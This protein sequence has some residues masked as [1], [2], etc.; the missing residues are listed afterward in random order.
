[1]NLRTPYRLLRPSAHA[2]R[3]LPVATGAAVG[4]ALVVVPEALTTKLTDAH[5]T[6]LLRL[7]AVCAALGA[8]FV[9]DDAAARSIPTVP[10]SR[11]TRN[12]VRVAVA[13]PAVAL[14]WVG[15]LRLVLTMA[16]HRHVP[17]TA[18]TLEAAAL[19]SASLALAAI[20]QRG[21]SDANTGLFAAPAVLAL[22]AVIWFLP[23]RVA[24]VLPPD[25]PQWTQSHRRW[26]TLLG[27]GVVVFLLAGRERA[28]RGGRS[29]RRPPEPDAGRSRELVSRTRNG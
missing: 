3:W 17:G 9:L 27:V 8:A 10:T 1:M 2:I 5:L 22:A 28:A 15:T 16:H 12:L 4:L 21:G 23:P 18:L 24:L 6:S 11:L 14:W 26:A 25:D 20:A 7:A 13:V 29:S 19:V